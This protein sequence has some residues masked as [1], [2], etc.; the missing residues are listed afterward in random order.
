MPKKP[1][2]TPLLDQLKEG[3]WP[4]FVEG[5]Q[6]L[7][8]DEDK[9]YAGMMKD[10]MGQLEHSYETRMGYWKGGAVGVYGYGGGVI[11][12]FSEV[13]DKFPESSEFH[14]LRIIPPAGMHYTTDL[15]R[16]MCNPHPRPDPQ[17]AVIRRDLAIDNAQQRGFAF[18]VTTDQANPL[19]TADFELNRLQ[20]MVMAKGERH[21]V[22]A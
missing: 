4:S 11:P 6:R 17:G 15:L 10:L 2:D 3:P 13:P 16:K 5:L 1:H 9:P 21:L 8:N 20:Q 19:A 14:T 7:A 12:R 18:T 22:Q